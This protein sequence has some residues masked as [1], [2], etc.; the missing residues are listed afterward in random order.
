[1]TA[2]KTIKKPTDHKAKAKDALDAALERPE[3]VK[4]FE[5]L[6]PIDS[7]PVWD[8]APLLS[9]VSRVTDSSDKEGK[10]EMDNADAILL[11]GQIA[12][13]MLPFAVDAKQF[14]KFCTGKEALQDVMT[15]AL[16]WTS[17][18]GE[19]ESSDDS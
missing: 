5:L 7:V 11:I 16:A 6:V 1:M 8:Q 13:A 14:T 17:V 3:D 10:I 12:K 2:K 4:G 9:L 15:L 19:G 18:L